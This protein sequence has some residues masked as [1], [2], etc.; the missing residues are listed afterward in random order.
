MQAVLFTLVFRRHLHSL[1]VATGPPD[2]CAPYHR[3]GRPAGWWCGRFLSSI[4]FCISTGGFAPVILEDWLTWRRNRSKI[5][6]A[7]SSARSVAIARAGGGL[8]GQI[9]RQQP[10]FSHSLI[11]PSAREDIRAA[12]GPSIL[13]P[14]DRLT[15]KRDAAPAPAPAIAPAMYRY[16]AVDHEQ[17]L[18]QGPFPMGRCPAHRCGGWLASPAI[19]TAASAI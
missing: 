11:C 1:I 16:D 9:H 17:R 10:A 7:R 5:R 15:G 8:P 4:A 18:R 12:R 19:L 3:A 6:Q 14:A 2:E 13:P